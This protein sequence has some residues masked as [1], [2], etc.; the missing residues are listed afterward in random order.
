MR[1]IHRRRFIPT[2]SDIEI[3]LATS[4]IADSAGRNVSQYYDSKIDIFSIMKSMA[5]SMNHRL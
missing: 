1:E 5:V 3:S 2:V 4:E